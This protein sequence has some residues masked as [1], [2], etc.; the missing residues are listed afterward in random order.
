MERIQVSTDRLRAGAGMLDDCQARLKAEA[1]F[2]SQKV[3]ELCD[4]WSGIANAAFRDQFARDEK[5]LLEICAGMD[6][7]AR[8][9]RAAGTAYDRCDA[10]IGRLVASVKI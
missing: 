9:L 3:Q 1:C 8:D 5:A 7:Y 6:Q 10:E 2:L 4:M